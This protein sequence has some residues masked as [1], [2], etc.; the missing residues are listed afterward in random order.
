MVAPYIMI[1]WGRWRRIL[2]WMYRY[3]SW[4]VYSFIIREQHTSERTSNSVASTHNRSPETA[5]EGK[6]SVLSH[7]HVR[8]CRKSQPRL[9]PAVG[10]PRNNGASWIIY[11]VSTADDIA[12]YLEL[13]VDTGHK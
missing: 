8:R 11:P 2:P 5:A 6:T 7:V 12:R 3:C 4:K 9:G 13:A 10:T 1:G